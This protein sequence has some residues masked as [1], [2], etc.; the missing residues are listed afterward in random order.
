ARHAAPDSV[1]R[2]ADDPHPL[3]SIRKRPRPRGVGTD[4][5]AEHLVARRGTACD[6]DTIEA[7]ARDEVARP[8]NGASDHC[9][10]TL[11]DDAVSCVAEGCRARSVRAD[12]VAENLD[13]GRVTS[14]GG[15]VGDE[16]PC[17]GVPRNHVS[18]AGCATTDGV[19]RRAHDPDTFNAVAERRGSRR[20]ATY[21]VPDQL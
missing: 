15:I 16:N 21:V 18:R 8:C 20:V 2:R 14:D 3:K 4:V 9:A 5:V 12:E 10:R 7:V 19:V 17:V 11:N 6:L 13:T 1:I